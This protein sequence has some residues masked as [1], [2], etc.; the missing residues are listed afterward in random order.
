MSTHLEFHMLL[1]LHTSG[2]FIL[3]THAYIYKNVV[4]HPFQCYA[5]FSPECPFLLLEVQD[6]LRQQQTS[7]SETPEQRQVRL[8]QNAL[9]HLQ[10]SASETPEQRQERL[11]Q[12][13]LHQQQTSASETLEQR[14]ER[15]QQNALCQQQ[16]RINIYRWDLTNKAVVYGF[17]YLAKLHYKFYIISPDTRELLDQPSVHSKL[18]RFHCSIASLP[19]QEM[20]YIR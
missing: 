12:N 20:L 4:S 17:I 9:H 10:S 14:Q 8:Q 5:P 3:C 19:V 2:V 16:R 15:L 7:A 18:L 13:A 1:H 11:Q 6:A